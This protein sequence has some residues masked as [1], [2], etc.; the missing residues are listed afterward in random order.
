MEEKGKKYEKVMY[1][2]I[3]FF[4]EGKREN[5]LKRG[6]KKQK[7]IKSNHLFSS[8]HIYDKQFTI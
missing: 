3:F 7:Q 5:G 2:E 4:R 6:E 1:G 8:V